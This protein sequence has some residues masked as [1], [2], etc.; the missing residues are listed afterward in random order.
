MLA[1]ETFERLASAPIATKPVALQAIGAKGELISAWTARLAYMDKH[2][3]YRHIKGVLSELVVADIN[4]DLRLTLLEN[5]MTAV[6]RLVLS[7]QQEYINNPQSPP[8]EQRTYVDE[9]RGLYFLLILCYQGV[10][11]RSYQILNA[12]GIPTANKTKAAKTSWVDKLKGGLSGSVVRSGMGVDLVG[13]EKRQYVLSVYHIMHLGYKLLL[14]YALTYQKAPG[15]VWKLMNDWYFKSASLA[16]D[17]VCVSKLANLGECSIYQRYLQSC[18]ASFA[19]LLSYRRPDILNGFKIIPIWAKYIK[20]TFK[21]SREFRLFVNL[22]G[23]TPPEL[24]TPYASINPYSSDYICLFF[25]TSGLFEYLSAVD[26]GKNEGT[27]GYAAFEKRLAKMVLMA[28][29]RQAD[30]TTEGRVRNQAAEILTGFGA[31]FKEMAGRPFNQVIAQSKLADM[32]LPQLKIDQQASTRSELVK[33]VRKNDA[34]VQFTLDTVSQDEVG[35]KITNCPY[36]PIFGLFAMKSSQSANKNPWR[37]G[38]VHWV[39]AKEDCIEVGG[40]FLGRVLSVCGIRL[41][42]RDMRGKDF[43][44]ALL[45]SGD[46]LN[47]QTTLVLPRYHFKEG[48]VVILRVEQKETSLRLQKNLLSTDEIEQ[49]EIVRLT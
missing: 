6:E 44:Q 13:G 46:E 43:V 21:A 38:L 40:R 33:L 36:L 30:D 34:S 2:E 24:I 12:A 26:S 49:Y 8:S 5:L 42:T 20:T 32:Y 31:T 41:N 10:A 22:Q 15:S 7:M 35:D 48:D 4:D 23:N 45:V 16:V 11:F 19:N 17:K 39:D 1:L 47:Q 9:V 29:Q 37:L 18:L 27:D 25:E 14:E 28:F 3:Q